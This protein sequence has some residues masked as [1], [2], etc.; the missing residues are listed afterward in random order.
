MTEWNPT[1]N[2]FG[3]CNIFVCL[4]YF[5]DIFCVC[6]IFVFVICFVFVQYLMLSLI[7]PKNAQ[8]YKVWSEYFALKIRSL[9]LWSCVFLCYFDSSKNF[10]YPYC[11][12]RA[13]CLADWPAL[14]F[15][16]QPQSLV[17]Q[18]GNSKSSLNSAHN[19]SWKLKPKCRN[20][21]TRGCT[22]SRYSRS[23][24]RNLPPPFRKIL[25]F[26]AFVLIWCF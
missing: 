17:S 20:L 16:W 1:Q 2:Q 12:E 25:Y 24:L 22:L 19:P 8:R 10:F 13:S 7:S 15:I 4:W 6:D 11:W 9:F 23:L 3:N 21:S 14:V 26:D 5:C 18:K